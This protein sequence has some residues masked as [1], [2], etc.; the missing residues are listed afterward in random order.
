[1][2]TADSSILI[3]RLSVRVCLLLAVLAPWRFTSSSI[4]DC[5]FSIGPGLS[6][7]SAPLTP[8]FAAIGVHLRHLCN[9]RFSCSDS[10]GVHRW[11][12]S[13]LGVPSLPLRTSLGA[14]AVVSGLLS[15]PL[16]SRGTTRTEGLARLSCG[17]G[18]DRNRPAI[19][20]LSQ[21]GAGSPAQ[22]VPGPHPIQAGGPGYRTTSLMPDRAQR[23][24]ASSFSSSE[25]SARIAAG[26][27]IVVAPELRLLLT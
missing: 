3:P 8:G 13:P 14:M 19:P 16:S 10:I 17:R 20:A 7:R 15:A 22:R 21:A 18:H 4:S 25:A 5:R 23:R 11:L 2:K 27:T 9:L 12:L 26:T 6:G 1:M 24:R